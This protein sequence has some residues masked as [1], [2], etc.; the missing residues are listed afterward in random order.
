MLTCLNKKVLFGLF[1]AL[2]LVKSCPALAAAAASHKSEIFEVFTDPENKRIHR[3]P[4][5]RHLPTAKEM[6]QAKKDG[7]NGKI[8]ILGTPVYSW[9][10]GIVVRREGIDLDKGLTLLKKAAFYGH[11][12]S[13]SLLRSCFICGI[14]G[15]KQNPTLSEA[16][17]A[18]YGKS[19]SLWEQ[20]ERYLAKGKEI[21]TK[22]L[23]LPEIWGPIDRAKK[24]SLRLTGPFSEARRVFAADPKKYAALVTPE[25]K[26]TFISY[27]N[28]NT[29]AESVQDQWLLILKEGGESVEKDL[30]ET[31]HSVRGWPYLEL[32]NFSRLTDAEFRRLPLDAL[33]EL[34]LKEVPS[35][36]LRSLDGIKDHLQV[37]KLEGVDWTFLLGNLETT[38]TSKRPLVFSKLKT[39][40]LIK[41]RKLIEVFLE[42]PELTYLQIK[43][44]PQLTTLKVEAPQLRCLEIE[45]APKLTEIL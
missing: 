27:L 31:H 10:T 43:D 18:S 41:A 39:L 26:A 9:I 12:E 25:E 3:V 42:A 44:M 28:W 40:C 4:I 8:M 1:V 38:F 13:C 11:P 14:H 30:L 36:S 45:A 5:V 22:I 6:E 33:Q 29:L 34:S 37:L 7:K 17:A 35:L 23:T 32:N 16:F 19:K 15:V 2:I 21:P 20:S 24:D